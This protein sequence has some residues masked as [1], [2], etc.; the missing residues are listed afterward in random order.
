MRAA[1]PLLAAA[2]SALT[3]RPGGAVDPGS[4]AASTGA[5]TSWQSAQ[6]SRRTAAASF[7]L[8]ETK[9]KPELPFLSDSTWESVLM[10]DADQRPVLVDVCAEWCGPCKVIHPHLKYLDRDGDVRVVKVW[11]DDAPEFKEWLVAQGEV[12]TKLPTCILFERGVPLRRLEGV[13][14]RE[15]LRAFVAESGASQPLDAAVGRAVP[16]SS[17]MQRSECRS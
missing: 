11:L 2:C 9:L 6:A 3:M 13:F 15:Q 5:A 17:S 16:V 8:S 12:V 14:T 4:T 10:N 7:T 1:L